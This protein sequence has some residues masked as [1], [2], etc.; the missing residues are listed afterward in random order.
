ML[1]WLFFYILS[2]IKKRLKFLVIIFCFLISNS[3]YSQKASYFD[4]ISENEGL[5]S[6]YIFNAAEDHN[7]VIWFGTD[8]G[9]VTYQDGKWLTLDID[10][11]MPGNYISNLVSDDKNGLLIY[12][13]NKGLYYFNTNTKTLL[14]KYNEIGNWN[15]LKIKLLGK[16]SYSD[17]LSK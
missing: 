15:S 14:K 8:K 2:I 11:G 13:L 17:M 6:N 5:P 10:N 4:N 1:C 7:H 16:P 9:L 12:V 3:Y